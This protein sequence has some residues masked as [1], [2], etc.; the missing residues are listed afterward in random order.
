MVIAT[1]KTTGDG[2]E[3][4]WGSVL[5]AYRRGASSAEK[6]T[7]LVLGDVNSGKSALLARA[8]GEQIPP[9]KHGV[10]LSY[11]FM[12]VFEDN[13][14]EPTGDIDVWILEGETH[15]R[16]LLRAS[17]TEDSVANGLAVICLDFIQPWLI[18]ESL[19][20]WLDFLR[21]ML[22]D[23]R[24]E[25]I[26]KKSEEQLINYLHKYTEPAVDSASK[27]RKKKRAPIV[28]TDETH[29]SADHNLLKFNLGIPIVVVCCKSDTAM[30]LEK[31]YD[32]KTPFFEFIQLRL[33]QICLNYGASLI[34]TSA[35]KDINTE[36]LM[37]YVEHRLFGMEF[38]YRA[39]LLENDSIFVPAG[40]DSSEKIQTDAKNLHVD[41][42][43]PFETV[44]KR[45][46]HAKRIAV[47]VITAEDD[48][49][50]M[51]KHKIVIDQEDS[52]IESLRSGSWRTPSA[53]L[54]LL[55]PS[56]PATSA[57]PTTPTSVSSFTPR[58]SALEDL[59]H[60]PVINTTKTRTADS[61]V[62]PSAKDKHVLA[63]FFDALLKSKDAKR[64]DPTS[65]LGRGIPQARHDVEKE[66]ERLKSAM[67]K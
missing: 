4:I 46:P 62:T 63:T 55:T 23:V 42:S 17:L 5:Q 59:S 49:A 25:T 14:E 24:S 47:P 16:D 29:E 65:P 41:L 22:V 48:V 8:R 13:A 9:L 28:I 60:T 39:N 2:E 15:H 38:N 64:T 3:D 30:L 12:N 44:V 26:D 54:S 10:A 66:L 6:G 32:I 27:A 1:T 51:N 52:E 31:D 18:E 40:W 33:R 45:P 37:D 61:F 21:K 20:K 34:F 50:F 57:Y 43:V 36:L 58:T 7:L 56:T 67:K 53:P 11:D 19:E 35:K